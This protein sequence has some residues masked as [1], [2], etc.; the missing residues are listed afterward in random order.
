MRKSAILFVRKTLPSAIRSLDVRKIIRQP[1]TLILGI[2]LL[3]IA[4]PVA[5]DTLRDKSSTA[6]ASL[7]TATTL[8]SPATTQAVELETELTQDSHQSEANN[9][10]VSARNQTKTTVTVNGQTRLSTE[11]PVEQKIIT[12]DGTTIRIES[13]TR[14][15]SSADEE[16]DND[17]DSDV[18]WDY[19]SRVRINKT[20]EHEEER[21]E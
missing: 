14:N 17:S 2:L 9:P 4:V 12:E 18:D 13:R 20:S 21:S 8:P 3:V 15:S 6:D 10:D 5:A 1:I 11:Q 7:E 16:A 19:D